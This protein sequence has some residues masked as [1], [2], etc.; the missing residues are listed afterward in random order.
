MPNLRF[1][2]SHYL[3][4]V[5]CCG[6]AALSGCG[7]GRPTRVPVSGVVL[8]DD[9]PLT[10]GYVRFAPP[11]SRA[12]AG[13]LNSDG[14]FTLTCFTPGDGAVLG[15]HQVSVIAQE[16]IGQETIKWHAPKK[17]ADPATSQLAEEISGPTDSIVIRL[18]WGDQ[19][20]PLVEHR[21]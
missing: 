18:T 17:Y 14:R 13:S 5:C 4:V 6:F 10:Y 1:P 20:G 2:S 21:R 15:K 3:I 16:P 7:D 12:S 19:K 9:Q 8:I 11:D